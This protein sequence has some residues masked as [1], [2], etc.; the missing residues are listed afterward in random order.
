MKVS[1]CGVL[2]MLAK[3]AIFTVKI[4]DLQIIMK[5]EKIILPSKS[6]AT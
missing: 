5:K 3:P 4:R 6:K 2:S 1:S